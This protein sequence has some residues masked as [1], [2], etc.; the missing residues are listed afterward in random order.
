MPFVTLCGLVKT[1]TEMMIQKI[2]KTQVVNGFLDKNQH[3]E[4]GPE[5]YWQ[6]EYTLHDG[7]YFAEPTHAS[8]NVQLDCSFSYQLHYWV[9]SVW[10]SLIPLY[11]QAYVS[12]K[13]EAGIVWD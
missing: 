7:H 11:L 1:Y 6:P 4:L 13:K 9:I 5:A 2:A 3:L 10:F 8:T 12:Q